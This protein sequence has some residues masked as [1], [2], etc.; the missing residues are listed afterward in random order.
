[1]ADTIAVREEI[2]RRAHVDA[3]TYE[4]LYAASVNDPEAFWAEQGK[5]LTWSKPFTKVK[6]TQ[7]DYPNVAIRWYEDGELNAAY[8]C[9]DRHLETRGDQTA[10]IWEQD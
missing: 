1:M 7:F 3:A 6:N 10:I 2:E 9:I 5:R 4:R 8:N